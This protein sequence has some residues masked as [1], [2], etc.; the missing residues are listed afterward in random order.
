MQIAVSTISSFFLLHHDMLVYLVVFFDKKIFRFKQ[1]KL[2]TSINQYIDQH[3]VEEAERTFNGIRRKER[4][5]MEQV[6]EVEIPHPDLYAEADHSLVNLLNQLD[7]SFSE[8]LFRL[9]DEKKE[10]QM[11][12]HIKR[13]NIDRRLFSKKFGMNQIILQRRKQ[14]LPLPLL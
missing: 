8:R 3:Y 12:R 9:I 13:A 7:E 10:R 6:K 2:F 4:Y 1:K 5:V 14:P 11:L